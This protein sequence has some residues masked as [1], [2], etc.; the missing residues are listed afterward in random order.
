MLI[1]TMG[2]SVSRFPLSMS[3]HQR[4][5]AVLLLCLLPLTACT[6]RNVVYTDTPRTTAPYNAVP[7]SSNFRT[8][9][10]LQL[11]AAQHWANIADDTGK[12]IATLLSKGS[13]CLPAKGTC[14]A[15]FI[16]PPVYVTEFSRTFHNQLLTTL[17]T[18]GLNVSKTPESSVLIDIDVQPVIFSANR[19]Q[20][21]YAGAATELGPGI[22]AL[23]DV[24]SMNPNDPSNSTA[25]E[26]A[27]HWFR[28]EFAAGRTPQMEIVVTV[29]ASTKTRYLARATNIYYVTAGDKRLYDQ[30][31]CSLIQPC[32]RSAEST[33]VV[34]E[35]KTPPVRER[36]IGVTGDCPLERVCC[37]ASGKPCTETDPKPKA[38]KGK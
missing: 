24:S 33:P 2:G 18:S 34:A 26:D 20:Y 1:S 38:V 25:D 8:S 17:V 14:E 11:Q 32:A 4:A 37:P 6:H 31:I 9:T 36:A 3:R 16:N 27:L 22:W 7:V 13:I 19:P 29:S 23:R 35:V 12:A 10:Q 5:T 15:V 30:E 21:R 28:T